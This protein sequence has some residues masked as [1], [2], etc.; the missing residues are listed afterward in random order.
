MSDLKKYFKK[1]EL[2]SGLTEFEK[3]E[4]RLNLGII[5]YVGESGQIAPIPITHEALWL[6]VKTNKVIVGGRYIITDFQTIYSSEML[7]TNG[8][9]LT[10]GLEINTTPIIPL[11]V[12]G[13]TSSSLDSR[14]VALGKDW[15]IEYDITKVR[16][17]DGLS[18]KG[19]I[20]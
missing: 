8:L 4:A 14:A 19:R 1:S 15:E 2:L 13:E 17:P 7:S 6:L 9:K 11:L 10:W 5:D 20:T 16:L 12:I 3:L 18:T